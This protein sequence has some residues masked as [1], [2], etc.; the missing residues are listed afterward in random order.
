M[1]FPAVAAR[2]VPGAGQARG[3]AAR[4][5]FFHPDCIVGSGVG[6]D[7]LTPWLARALAGSRGAM[8]AV[9]PT[10]GGEFHPALKTFLV[11]FGAGE[12]AAGF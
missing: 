12:P 10:A 3:G 8:E 1:A 5:V 7:L 4:A 9:A 2:N 6:P 11:G